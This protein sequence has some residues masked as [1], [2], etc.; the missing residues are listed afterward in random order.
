MKKDYS[1]SL[2]L[3]I[4]QFQA[5]LD[6][7]CR[8]FN[9]ERFNEYLSVLVT[10]VEAASQKIFQNIRLEMAKQGVL[11]ESRQ[12]NERIVA[13]TSYISA[14][15]YSTDAKVKASAM[16]LK[17]QFNSFDK[18]IIHMKVDG[19]L[20]AVRALLRDLSK[21]EM[22][23]HVENLP[24]LGGLLDDVG[25]AVDELAQKR[26][27]VDHANSMS[28][29]PQSK[30]AL[31]REAA[32]KLE[33]LLDYL[34]VMTEKDASA[35]KSHYDVVVEV[36]AR[37]NRIGRAKPSNEGKATAAVPQPSV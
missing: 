11:Q 21:P 1:F 9:D 30:L 15:C 7:I 36:V 31:K 8:H 25:K 18:P 14:M 4:K 32:A 2:G 6:E 24:N 13:A 20:V 5:G 28:V 35:Y 37:I 33:T 22:K 29:A 19:R 17:Q 23:D 3:E 10:E 16:L 27:E 26:L 34:K 12:L